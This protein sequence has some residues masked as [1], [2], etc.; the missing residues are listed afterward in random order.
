[1]M[2]SGWTPVVGPALGLWCLAAPACVDTTPGRFVPVKVDAAPP[3]SPDSGRISACEQCFVGDGGACRTKWDQ[4]LRF[5]EC[6][7]LF[8]CSLDMGCMG[9]ADLQA[10]VACAGPC[11]ATHML[12]AGDPLIALA[13]LNTCTDTGC[14]SA[15]Q[16]P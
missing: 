15:C 8:R 9:I 7:A 1:M 13:D 5:P 3:A 11:L 2:R 4:C 12:P 10:R 16:G 6:V 14:A